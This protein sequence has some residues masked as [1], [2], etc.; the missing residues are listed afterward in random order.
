MMVPIMFQ[1]KVTHT[2]AMRM[3]MGHSS[4]A[5]SF[6]VVKPRTRVMA[7]NRMMSCHPQKL[8]AL[9][10]SLYILVFSSFCME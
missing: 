5:Y 10:V 3:S 6:E 2:M 1:P 8:M 7:A 9:R 4:S